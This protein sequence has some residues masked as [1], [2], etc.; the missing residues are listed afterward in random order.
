M[1]SCSLVNTNIS[2]AIQ[3]ILKL[4]RYV[5]RMCN[6]TCKTRGF[7]GLIPIKLESTRTYGDVCVRFG[8][9]SFGRTDPP[10][11]PP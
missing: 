10:L 6:D 1:L 11:P 2:H 8:G 4:S 3:T 9:E 5:S 7:V